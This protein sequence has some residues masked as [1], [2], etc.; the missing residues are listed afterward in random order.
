MQ[1]CWQH[2][3]ILHRFP[4]PGM[5]CSLPP[6]GASRPPSLPSATLLP[7]LFSPPWRHQFGPH[8]N[9]QAVQGHV[10]LPTRPSAPE[11]LDW[12][13]CL[14]VP[15]AVRSQRLLM[16]RRFWAAVNVVV[17]SFIPV[18]DGGGVL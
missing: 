10:G 3:H 4:P 6:V 13:K 12:I 5:P 1:D 16:W 18:M 11:L 8:V 15:S 14:F 17:V 2:R 7:P 9:C